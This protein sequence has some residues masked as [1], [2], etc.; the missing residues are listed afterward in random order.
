M[1]SEHIGGLTPQGGLEMP[2]SPLFNRN[3]WYLCYLLFLGW[4]GAALPWGWGGEALPT[5]GGSFGDEGSLH[6]SQCLGVPPTPTTTCPQVPLALSGMRNRPCWS[7]PLRGRG[8]C[9]FS[10]LEWGKLLCPPSPFTPGMG[11][12]SSPSL[13]SP[14]TLTLT[15]PHRDK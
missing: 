14:F 9:H 12:A 5:M 7:Q 10:P 3:L 11:G 15:A 2:E 4:R 6:P 13:S 1:S 8:K